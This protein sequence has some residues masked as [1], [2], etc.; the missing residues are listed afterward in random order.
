[1]FSNA[2]V[3]Q[4]LLSACNFGVGLL[5]IR[6]SSNM[7]YGYY[8]LAASTTLLLTGLQNAF[9]QPPMVMRLVRSDRTARAELLG[10]IY[11]EQ[12][13]LLLPLAIFAALAAAALWASG[14]LDGGTALIVL[15]GIAASL[16]ALYREFFRMVLF[17]YRRAHEVLR[18]DI[19]YVVAFFSAAVLATFTPAP[20]LYT[21]LLQSLA[22]VGGGLLLSKAL[23]RHEPWR[24]PGARGVLREL[25]PIGIWS[26]AGSVTHWAFSQG[27]NYLVA[28]TL[29][30]GAVAAIAATRLLMMPVNLLSTGICSLMMPTATAW[31]QQHGPATVFRRLLLIASGLAAMSMVYFALVWL[32]REAIF[33]Y[34]LRK[35]FEHGDSLLIAWS[36]VFVVMLFRD[37][38]QYLPGASGRY[39][40]LSA[41]TLLSAAVSLT[42]VYVAISR[43]GIVWAPLGVLAGEICNVAGIVFLSIGIIRRAAPP[44]HPA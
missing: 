8:V 11:R 13:Q 7:Q 39:R 31:L 2:V 37:Q 38:L 40:S 9:I 27:Y 18:A 22:A 20:A 6:R 1:M 35:H 41:V 29:D 5:L 17:G 43:F 4:A 3:T 33:S 19:V 30:I 44:E 42:T 24:Y 12:R 21:L 23:W 16:G 26:T 34:V 14:R 36:A 25:A 32:F 15:A 10:G 28:G